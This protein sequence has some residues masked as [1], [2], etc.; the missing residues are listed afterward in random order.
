MAIGDFENNLTGPTAR[1]MEAYGSSWFDMR[2]AAQIIY[3]RRQHPETMDNLFVRRGLLD[4]AVITYA[5]CFAKGPRTNQADIRSLLE[6]LSDEERQ[7]HETVLQWR[8]KHVGHRVD[9]TL[10]DV[11][12]FLLW[13]DWGRNAP[14]VRLRLVTRYTPALLDFDQRFEDLAL[15]LSISI[16]EEFLYPLQQELL[17]DLGPEKLAEF[18]QES[19]VW[20]SSQ[21]APG[22]FAVNLDIGSQLPGPDA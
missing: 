16:W 14:T 13:G 4:G 2:A 3:Q 19:A 8:D 6:P 11:A 22:A 5:R 7:I 18:K 1:K 12:P 10:E 15:R 20:H 17:A 9:K 21:V